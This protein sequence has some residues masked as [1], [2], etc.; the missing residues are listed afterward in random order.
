MLG[1]AYAASLGGVA[2]LIGTPPNAVLAGA[3]SELLGRQIG[4]VEWMGVGVPVARVM[5]P[6]AWLLLTRV[7]HPPGDLHGDAAG[8]I[9]AERDALGPPPGARSSRA[10]SSPSRRW[11]GCCARRRPSAA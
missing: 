6:A 11:P 8:I 9:E 3:A 5:L 1:V 10:R 7:L 2:T 4:F